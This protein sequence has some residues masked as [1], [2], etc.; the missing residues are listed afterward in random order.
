MQSLTGTGKT[1]AFLLPILDE[2]DISEE[3]T[4]AVIVTRTRELS[5]KISR[6]FGRLIVGTKIV[7]QSLTGGANPAR[8]IKMYDVLCR[9]WR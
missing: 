8:L 5:R 9:M 4:H 1:L 2:I 3:S 6:Q 7:N